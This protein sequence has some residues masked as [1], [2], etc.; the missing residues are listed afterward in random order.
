MSHAERS[1]EVE[2]SRFERRSRQ[3]P[4][5]P[6]FPDAQ[7]GKPPACRCGPAASRHAGGVAALAPVAR[8]LSPWVG[9]DRAV[10]PCRQPRPAQPWRGQP[11]DFAP[12]PAWP[13][14]SPQAPGARAGRGAQPLPAVCH[15]RLR[16]ARPGGLAAS[17]YG[18]PMI[19]SLACGSS[20]CF[21]PSARAKSFRGRG[22]ALAPGQ[23]AGALA[24]R[25]RA[26]AGGSAVRP[27]PAERGA[28]R[29]RAHPRGPRPPSLRHAHQRPRGHRRARRP[30]A[31]SSGPQWSR[32]SRSLQSRSHGSAFF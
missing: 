9:A 17:G 10:S 8:D 7:P 21:S 20:R 31:H 1:M 4:R 14:H 16:P 15:R 11:P 26:G 29:G 22:E 12:P 27:P 5:T 24:A 32:L 19:C 13:G 30:P 6:F 23:P 18:L 28:H 25:G 2:S 3:D